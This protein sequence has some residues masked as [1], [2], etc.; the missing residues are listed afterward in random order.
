M[1]HLSKPLS[2]PG[3]VPGTE[4]LGRS[5]IYVPAADSTNAYL[6]RLARKGQEEGTVVAADS[7]W[8]GR[9]RRGRNWH[10]APG[11]GLWFSVLLRPGGPP[12]G[13]LD[14]SPPLGLITLMA[15]VAAA[16]AI[17]AAAG[18]GTVSGG[19]GAGSAAAAAAGGRAQTMVSGAGDTAAPPVG[20][21]PPAGIKWP[22]DVLL[23]GRKTAGILA[24][25]GTGPG[26]EQRWV[27]LGIGINVNHGPKDFPEDLRSKAVSIAAIRGGPVPREPLFISLIQNLDRLY[28]LWRQGRHGTMLNRWRELCVHM[29]RPVTV[30]GSG[31]AFSGRTIDVTAEGLLAVETDSGV[32]YAAAGEVSL[33]WDGCTGP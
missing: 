2:L 18:G 21:T 25:S 10:S 5:V 3:A 32:R 30:T 15:G 12:G 19:S 24:E 6:A 16:E 33:G 23:G 20:A 28:A 26:R 29:G 9:G 4:L 14:T 31:V 27:A 11:L 13:A 7:Q 17:G 1:K 8:A 22:N